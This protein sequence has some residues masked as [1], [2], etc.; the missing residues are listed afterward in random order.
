MRTNRLQE[1]IGAAVVQDQFNTLSERDKQ[2]IL[3]FLRSL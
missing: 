2:A 3:D 1:I